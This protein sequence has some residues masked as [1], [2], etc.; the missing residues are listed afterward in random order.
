MTRSK[1]LVSVN[2]LKNA[3]DVPELKVLSQNLTQANL[4]INDGI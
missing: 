1:E 3:K 2:A 4:S